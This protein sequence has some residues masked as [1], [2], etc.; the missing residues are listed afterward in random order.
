L[1]GWMKVVRSDDASRF[2]QMYASGF[3]PWDIGRPDRN[4][5]ER[6]GGLDLPG[7]R[8]LEIGC[9]RGDNA[10]F[11]ASMGLEVTATEIVPQALEDARAKAEKAGV[12]ITFLLLDIMDREIPGRP[13][14]LAFDRGC[15]HHYGRPEDRSRF[16]SRIA[17]HLVP[18]GLWL[19]LCGNADEDRGDRPGPPQLSA[20][21]IVKAA[22]PFF[23]IISLEAA[24]FDSNMEPPPMCWVF[25]AERR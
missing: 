24:R 23:R 14:H 10:I 13:F 4:L 20:L 5:K 22:E 1:K 17:E 25:L 21:D 16:A 8:A 11:L 2:G 9:G 15:F 3:T 18:G 19:S 12:R 6:L 7:P